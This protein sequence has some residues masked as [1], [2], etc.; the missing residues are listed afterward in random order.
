MKKATSRSPSQSRPS[1]TKH[2][3]DHEVPT[4]IHNPE[5][6]MM[7][8]ARWTH[9]AMRN[10][11]LFWG[12]LIG[13]AGAVLGIVLLSQLVS[14]R[15]SGNAEIWS[16]L[17]T[18][19]SPNDRIE[20]ADNQ[21]DS[22]AASWARLQAATEFYNQGFA[23][24]PNNRDTALPV[25]KKA[26]DQFDLVLK[27]AP[28]DSPQAK[29]A[30]MGKARTLEARNELPKAIE[31]YNLV[32]KTWPGTP[33]A[34]QA[35]ELAEA[36][37]KPGAAEFYKGLYAYSP[38][39]VTLPPLG[40]DNFNL[41]ILPAPGSGSTGAEANPVGSLPSI[42]L[43]PPPPPVPA[44]KAESSSGKGSSSAEPA[45]TSS[46]TKDSP[47]IPAVPFAPAT[48]PS[49]PT[50]PAPVPKA[51]SPKSIGESTTATGEKPKS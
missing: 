50:T 3:F 41:P 48:E 40:T 11:N 26:L 29:V 6:N 44:A 17:E 2:Q 43:L 42:P 31:Q 8:L 28:K 14:S 30:A 33:E 1:S 25:L 7:V 37:S 19:K 38:S 15:T 27:D 21:P 49:T 39:K 12:S 23:D 35:K 36:L 16:K 5:E 9:R 47:T 24:L 45:K 51:A 13:I 18:A 22:P 32:A 20:I 46:S 34:A 10:P 4:V